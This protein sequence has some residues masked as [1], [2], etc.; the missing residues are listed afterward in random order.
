MAE[1]NVSE[2]VFDAVVIRA[3]MLDRFAEEVQREIRAILLVLQHELMN[4]LV[5]V[6]PVGVRAPSY[7]VRRAQKLFR[8]V[9]LTMAS[10]FRDMRKKHE[11]ELKGM[12]MQEG[13]FMM[14]AVNRA[15]G[16]DVMSVGLSKEQ[17]MALS[18]EELINGAP[19]RDWWKRQEVKLRESFMDHVRNGMLRGFSTA[20]IAGRMKGTASIGFKD[21][22]FKKVGRAIESLVR[23][24]VI[25]SANSARLALMKEN[26]DVLSGIQWVSTLDTRTTVISGS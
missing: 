1:N 6:D 5:D 25:N 10:S 21:G 11:L 24:S 9:K 14:G 4:E 19:S 18:K 23:T 12:M 17:L 16:V 2:V 20:E 8:Q 13:Q 15:V 26:E 7:Q 22:I 3:L